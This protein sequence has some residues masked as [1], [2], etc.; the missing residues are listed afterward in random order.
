[1]IKKIALIDLLGQLENSGHVNFKELKVALEETE[2]ARCCNASE[3]NINN[4]ERHG[5]IRID[6]DG[7]KI[8]DL[9]GAVA[10]LNREPVNREPGKKGRFGKKLPGYEVAAKVAGWNVTTDGEHIIVISSA[11][12]AGK[13][14]YR[15]T[16]KP[17]GRIR[18]NQ[19]KWDL[20]QL[21]MA[22]VDAAEQVAKEIIK[23]KKK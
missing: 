13:V 15:L 7:F 22:A 6:A 9:V 8:I 21:S 17:N 3:Y 16:Y 12:R 1:M 23:R 18:N 20:G 5:Y 19:P 4:L 11:R 14:T 10:W 2:S